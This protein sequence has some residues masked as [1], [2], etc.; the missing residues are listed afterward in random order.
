MIDCDTPSFPGWLADL[1]RAANRGDGDAHLQMG[2]IF[3]AGR[4][5][6][7]DLQRS[8]SHF[9]CAASLGNRAAIA[10]NRAF[11]ANGTGGTPD[12]LKAV[13]LLEED[14]GD[15]DAAEQLSLI[16]AMHLDDRGHP[17][18][19]PIGEVLNYTPHIVSFRNFVTDVEADFLA[20]RAASRF[21]PALVVHPV[22]RLQVPDPIRTSDI[23]AFPLALEQ[24]AIHAINLRI[25]SASGT[26]VRAGEPLTIL[27]YRPGQQYR[28]HLDTLP[29]ERNQ[30]VATMLIYLNDGYGGGETYFPKLDLKVFARKGDA[31]LFVNVR[32]DGQP[33]PLTLHEGV[34]VLAGEKLVASR[35]I[36][37]EPI[38]L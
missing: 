5:M 14:N 21:Q 1:E 2:R 8:R 25:A 29:G 9:A 30:R 15:L 37:R 36:R 4:D 33:E 12:W 3:L 26:N 11:V 38:A 22:T 20:G 13:R 28:P 34:R 16:A 23:A 10:V 6:P 24:P 7:R 32:D 35:W 17:I 19:V 18:A 27:R 31:L